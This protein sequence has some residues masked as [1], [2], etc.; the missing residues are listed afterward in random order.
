[1]GSG[2][3]MA[4]FYSYSRVHS[5]DLSWSQ[6]V[7]SISLVQLNI[8]KSFALFSNEIRDFAYG[9]LLCH[10]RFGEFDDAII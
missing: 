4:Y 10:V 6:I 5:L 9:D 7:V 3:P 8:V 2:I 1:M